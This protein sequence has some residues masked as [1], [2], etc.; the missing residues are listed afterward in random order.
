MKCCLKILLK[1]SR[2]SLARKILRAVSSRMLREA[3]VEGNA[4]A[5]GGTTGERFSGGGGGRRLLYAQTRSALQT[6]T[7]A[8]NISPGE[9][10]T[11]FTV[12]SFTE[13]NTE[14]M[15]VERRYSTP[16]RC[17]IFIRPSTI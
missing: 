4:A 12:R 7:P 13:N 14:L 5:G 16:N 6:T 17:P 8:V 9:S 1:L 15:G 3:L 10:A 11:S 2:N